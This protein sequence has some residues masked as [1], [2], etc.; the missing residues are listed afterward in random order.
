MQGPFKGPCK[1]KILHF[2]LRDGEK[3]NAEAC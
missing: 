3:C 1:V 2:N